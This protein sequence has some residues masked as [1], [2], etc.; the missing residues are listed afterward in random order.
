MDKSERMILLSR[1]KGALSQHVRE[2]DPTANWIAGYGNYLA[3]IRSNLFPD[4][5]P[6][7]YQN[8]YSGGAG[9]ELEWDFRYGK[10]WPPKMHA[11]HSSSALVVNSFAPWKRHPEAVE[12]CGKRGFLRLQFEVK[13]RTPLG[14]TPPHLD[15]LAEIGDSHI[16][17]GESKATEYLQEH[18]MEF[19][20]SYESVSWLECVRPYMGMMRQLKANPS[21]FIY[22]DAA[23]LIK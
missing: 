9:G 17:A 18:R 22:L 6:D 23:Q 8:E 7:L 11:A 19:S 4:I 5:D 1:C 20:S 2:L 13:M 10:R 21:T 12:L 16:V 3:D 15:F 14:G